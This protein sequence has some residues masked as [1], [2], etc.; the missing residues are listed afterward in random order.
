MRWKFQF[1]ISSLLWLT[2]CFALVIASLVMHHRMTQAEERIS[3]A[4]QLKTE[5]ETQA[6]VMRKAASYLVVGDKHL[7][8]GIEV[9][10]YEP[11]TNKWRLYLPEQRRFVLK[12]ASGEIPAQGTPTGKTDDFNIVGNGESVLFMQIRHREDDQWY[13]ILLMKTKFSILKKAR[14][15]PVL[16][17]T[18]VQVPQ[19]F[20]PRP[21]STLGRAGSACFPSLEIP[22]S[23]PPSRINRSS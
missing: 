15:W 12:F 3:R 4:E 16:R 22:V 19:E 17:G 21:R 9:K 20:P 5:A 14:M 7:V 11:F 8:H 18:V 23:R 13:L 6:A 10:I 1:S 2:L